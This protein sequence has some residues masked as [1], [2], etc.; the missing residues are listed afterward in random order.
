M[1]LDKGR[2]VDELEKALLTDAEL[3]GGAG[4]WKQLE[5]VF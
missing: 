3:A 4:A 2:I 1:Q 5:D